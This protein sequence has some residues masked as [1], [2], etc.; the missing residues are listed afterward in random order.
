M[1]CGSLQDAILTQVANF[2]FLKCTQYLPV[3]SWALGKSYS[4]RLVFLYQN[5]FISFA[6]FNHEFLYI[7]SGLGLTLTLFIFC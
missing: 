7:V 2:N 3:K 6:I 4:K 5:K 1:I